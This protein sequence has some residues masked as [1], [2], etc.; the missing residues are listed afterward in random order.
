MWANRLSGPAGGR[1]A[2]IQTT[3]H[4]SMAEFGGFRNAAGRE[5]VGMRFPVVPSTLF[6]VAPHFAVELDGG[7]RGQSAT[8]RVRVGIGVAPDGH[9]RGACRWQMKG[10]VVS[11]RRGGW[12]L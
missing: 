1:G 10:R 4:L 7:S 3:Q 8:E 12:G 6:G 2:A 11:A 5:G 9:S